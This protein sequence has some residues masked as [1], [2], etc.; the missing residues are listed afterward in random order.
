[1]LTLFQRCF[2]ET[3]WRFH[4]AKNYTY[5]R[6]NNSRELSKDF[7]AGKT[8]DARWKV[9]LSFS[10]C[11]LHAL[12]T[13]AITWSVSVSFRLSE[14]KAAQ[15]WMALVVCE[16]TAG[17][18]LACFTSPDSKQIQ[19]SLPQKKTLKTSASRVL[20]WG[21]GLSCCL[22]FGISINRLKELF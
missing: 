17:P 12:E 10:F 11:M 9:Y 19:N 1:V 7:V 6:M 3:R 4:C 16:G 22:L 21:W 8:S 20:N 5:L 15:L 2:M 13:P 18:V 14:R